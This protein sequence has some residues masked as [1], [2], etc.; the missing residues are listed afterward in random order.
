VRSW[1]GF[2]WIRTTTS[3]GILWICLRIFG[4][5]IMR[6]ISWLIDYC[7]LVR[8]FAPWSFLMKCK[9]IT[10]KSLLTQTATRSILFP[11][12]YKQ[13]AIICAYIQQHSWGNSLLQF[14]S[15]LFL[16][17]S[18][19]FTSSSSKCATAPSGPGPLI[20][21]ASRSHSDTPHLAG[22]LW[23]SDQPDAEISTW[24]RS[25]HDRETFMPSAAFEPAIPAS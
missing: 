8:E 9:V 5:Y 4:F 18:S 24:Q 25:T 3:D 17:H 13:V 16:C 7:L 21:E 22:L 19:H 14:H 20:V 23:T 2:I 6:E 1:I 15:L 10:Y 12:A 11:A